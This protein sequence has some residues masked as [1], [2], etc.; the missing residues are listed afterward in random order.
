MIEKPSTDEVLLP[1]HFCSDKIMSKKVCSHL[2][3]CKPDFFLGDTIIDTKVGGTLAKPEQL[4][5]YLDHADRVFVITI[6]DNA[7]IKKLDN[8]TVVTIKL[9]TFLERSLEIIGVKIP[10]D[11]I[12]GLTRVLKDAVGLSIP[13]KN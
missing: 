3:R 1:Q 6:N 4:E 11:E 12:N 7:K 10:K 5:R 8:G 13:P 2:T 9:A